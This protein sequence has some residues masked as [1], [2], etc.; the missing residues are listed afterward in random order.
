M[1]MSDIWKLSAQETA[2]FIQKRDLSA[3]DSVGAALARL[4][5]VNPNLNAVVETLAETALQQAKALD[6][7]QADGGFLGPLHGVPVTI[8]INIDQEDCATSNGVVAF[9][10]IIAQA[11]APVVENLR[12]AGA[13]IIGRTNTPEFSFR[14]DTQNPLFGRTH[15]PW[16]KHL[17]AGGSSGGAG[18]AVMAGIGALAH[19]NDIGGSL[20]FPAAANGAVT[21]KPGLG[22]VPA[23]NASQKEERGI[24][25]QAMSVQGLLARRAGDLDLAMPSLMQ[26]HSGDPFHVPLPYRLAKH[27][28]PVR[29]AFCPDTPGFETHPEIRKGLDNAAAALRDA[30]YIV[31]QT[32]PPLLEETALMGYRSLLGEVSSLLGADIK[33]YGSPQVQQIFKDYFDYFPPFEGDA[34][35]KTLGQR[36]HYARQWGLFMEKYPLILAP[37][38]PQPFFAPNRDCEGLAGVSDVLGAALWSYSINFIGHPSGCLPA[39]LAEI[40]GQPYPINVQLIAQRWREDLCVAALQDIEARLG[41]LCDD[42]WR[43][44]GAS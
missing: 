40:K 31:E 25:A 17:S 12:K 13:V 42:L 35:L 10:D 8:K 39:G 18:A 33:A 32:D 27:D 41:Y 44:M 7:L 16:G 26:P 1:S 11:D 28:G 15:N 3:H 24:L 30:G 37:F 19:G 20:R 5:A 38:L 43:R 34:L 14:A 22:R 21:L 6:Q 4:D 9:K 2:S 36:T 29:V 23:W